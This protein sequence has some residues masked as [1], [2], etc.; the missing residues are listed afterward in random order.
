VV[1]AFFTSLSCNE[2]IKGSLFIIII[3]GRYKMIRIYFEVAVPEFVKLKV[4]AL[5][6]DVPEN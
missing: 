1:P 2:Q 6:V 4:I 5:P 3:N